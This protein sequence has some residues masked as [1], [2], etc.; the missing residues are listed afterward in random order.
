MGSRENG[1]RKEEPLPAEFKCFVGGISW[2]MDDVKLKDEFGK[3]SPKDARVML[4]KI[5]NRSRGFGFV[6]FDTKEDME[7]AIAGMHGQDIDGRKISVTRAI[8]QN[9]TAPGTPAAALAAGRRGDRYG[10]DRYG[11]RERYDRGGG[12]RY[13]GYGPGPERGYGGRDRGGYY[14]GGYPERGGYP[15]ERGYYDRAPEYDRGYAAPAYGAGYERAGY[16]AD[17]YAYSRDPA[18]ASRDPYAA[19]AYP[20]HDRSGY[21]GYD[22]AAYGAEYDRAAYARYEGDRAAPAA[23]ARTSAERGPPP[24]ADRYDGRTG[25]SERDYPP[26][27]YPPSSSRPGPYDRAP[28]G[29][30]PGPGR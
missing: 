29:R 17:P 7:A 3:Y 25:V 22:R 12:D 23:Y 10:G 24:A 27:R 2:H 16:A 5:T 6:M 19:A 26:S 15:P 1:D 14:G 8:P 28:V 21:A 13:R 30:D 18:Y 9:E 4:D 20:A 11:G